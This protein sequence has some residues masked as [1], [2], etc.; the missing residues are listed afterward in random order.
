MSLLH[1]AKLSKMTNN[2]ST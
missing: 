1:D 2:M